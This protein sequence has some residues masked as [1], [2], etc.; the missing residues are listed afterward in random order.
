MQTQWL[1][2][3]LNITQNHHERHLERSSSPIVDHSSG[4]RYEF[5]TK[6]WLVFVLTFKWLFGM[7][8]TIVYSEAAL[9]LEGEA[10]AIFIIVKLVFVNKYWC[11]IMQI[12]WDAETP[13]SLLVRNAHSNSGTYPWDCFLTYGH[14]SGKSHCQLS[15]TIILLRFK[16]RDLI[17]L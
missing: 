8:I 17:D 2:L 5:L 9:W 3:T 12:L 15:C 16:Q 7:E 13:V 10:S 4:L 14:W 11:S 1:A 6:N